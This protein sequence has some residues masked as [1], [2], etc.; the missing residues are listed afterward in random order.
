MRDYMLSIVGLCLMTSPQPLHRVRC[1]ASCFNFQYP[2][3]LLRSSSSCVRLL[4]CLSI[5]SIPHSMFP[6]ITCFRRQFQTQDVTNLI[7]LSFSLFYVEC[8][9]PTWVCRLILIRL[10]G[11]VIHKVIR[12]SYLGISRLICVWYVYPTENI[13][14]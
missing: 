12:I 9:S 11:Y 2:F 7:T 13:F 5:T 14:R 6:S 3:I 4:P 10:Q 1:T 8:S